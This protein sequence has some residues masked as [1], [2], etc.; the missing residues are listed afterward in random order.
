MG[1]L[2]GL[3]AVAGLATTTPSAS[4]GPSSHKLGERLPSST[5]K[6]SAPIGDELTALLSATRAALGPDAASVDRQL[7]Q[8]GEEGLTDTQLKRWLAARGWDPARAAADLAAHAAWRVANVPAGFVPESEVA[9]QIAHKKVLMQGNDRHG[10]PVAIL[11]GGRHIPR[12]DPLEVMKFYCYASDVAIAMAD[13]ERNPEGRVVFILDVGEFGLKNFDL[14]GAKSLATMMRAH[15]V[16]RL[17]HIYFHNAGAVMMQLFRLVSPFI[18]PVT[19]SKVVFLPSD[20]QEAAAILA[21]DIDLEM[22]PPNLGG[23]AKPRP[24]EKVWAE[25]RERRAEAAAAAAAAAAS[26]AA[27]AAAAAA[28]AAAA[29]AAC[30]AAVRDASCSSAGSFASCSSRSSGDG[31]VNVC[32]RLGGSFSA[33]CDGAAACEEAAGASHQRAEVAVLAAA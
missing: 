22:L 16:E 21:K 7:Q 31:F 19:R 24:V 1:L 9:A 10:R 23:S 8:G 28:G 13:P 2:S 32:I 20:P 33:T 12:P 6:R 14:M 18:D 5:R 17:S 25:I 26:S 4:S 3:G 30:P 11:V 15:Y 27:A 29:A